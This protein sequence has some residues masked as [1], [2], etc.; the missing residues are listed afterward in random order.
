[1]TY[2]YVGFHITDTFISC[3]KC[4]K[5][6]DENDDDLSY[7]DLFIKGTF[8]EKEK[9]LR[10]L[11]NQVSYFAFFWKNGKT[12]GNCAESR[13]KVMERGRMHDVGDLIDVY[14]EGDNYL[15]YYYDLTEKTIVIDENPL[16][17]GEPGI[18]WD[19]EESEERYVAIPK[20]DSFEAYKLRESFAE[21][22]E[23]EK[24]AEKIYRALSKKKPF[25]HFKDVLYETELWDEWNSFEHEYAKKEI[26]NWLKGLIID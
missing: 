8:L 11:K 3:S 16:I 21:S 20:M 4:D 9:R 23:K 1:M 18:D 5:M 6:I 15:S 2:G 25:R 24:V 12:N 17:T 22:L 13:K 26:E 14:L 7:D 10:C 19:D